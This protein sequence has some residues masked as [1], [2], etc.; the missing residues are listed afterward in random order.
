[1]AECGNL[2]LLKRLIVLGSQFFYFF[3]FI[4]IFF[5]LE[6]LGFLFRKIVFLLF[7]IS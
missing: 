4:S 6:F 7:L 2:R 5:F 1:M 3:I